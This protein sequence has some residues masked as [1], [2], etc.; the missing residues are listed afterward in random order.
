MRDRSR[1][2]SGAVRQNQHRQ[3]FWLSDR[4]TGRAFSSTCDNGVCGVR[5]RLQRRDRGG[6]APPSLQ[7]ASPRG[8]PVPYLFNC[9]FLAATLYCASVRPADSLPRRVA[10]CKRILSGRTIAPCLRGVR[11]CP[12]CICRLAERPARCGFRAELSADIKGR[13][14]IVARRLGA[15]T[16]CNRVID[17]ISPTRIR[18]GWSAIESRIDWRR[19]W[20]AEKAVHGPS[21]AAPANRPEGGGVDSATAGYQMTPQGWAPCPTVYAPLRPSAHSVAQEWRCGSLPYG[22]PQRH[23]HFLI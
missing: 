11:Q 17:S 7:T 6:F 8:R 3:V 12:V 15:F 19:L 18:I 4:S 1:P 2:R 9:Q 21:R 20:P 5:P 16:T 23:F 13:T 14:D 22:G 10:R